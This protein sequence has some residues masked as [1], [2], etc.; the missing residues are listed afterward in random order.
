MEGRDMAV[1][2]ALVHDYLAQSGGAERVVAALHG[3]FPLAPLY[4]SVYDKE[5]TLPCFAGM[6]I[7][8]SFL[9]S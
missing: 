2:T 7:R 5:A 1:R 9:Q 4:T 6:D 8:T 3:I